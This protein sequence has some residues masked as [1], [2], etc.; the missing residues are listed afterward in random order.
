MGIRSHTDDDQYACMK[1]VPDAGALQNNDE[2]LE[3]VM[4]SMKLNGVNM[5]M[6]PQASP[7]LETEIA[8]TVANLTTS[9]SED[10]VVVMIDGNGTIFINITIPDGMDT[11]EICGAMD[12]LDTKIP[13]ILLM[14]VLQKNG[15]TPSVTDFNKRTTLDDLIIFTGNVS[16]VSGAHTWPLFQL[17]FVAL[18]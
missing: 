2:N 14:D 13:T 4:M 8:K 10:S 1:F 6:L 12:D 7:V 17:S 9:I 18:L 3:V 16:V 5:A 15:E 11:V